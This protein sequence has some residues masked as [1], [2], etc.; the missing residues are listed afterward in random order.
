MKKIYAK[1]AKFIYSILTFFVFSISVSNCQTITTFAGNYFV[2][3]G[4]SGDGGL[5]VNAQLNAPYGIAVD[6]AGNVYFADYANN[7]IR[8]I[9]A[10][11]HAIST[12][13]GNGQS[14]YSGDGGAA[15]SAQ[16]RLPTSVAIDTA[17]NLYIGDASYT[18]RKVDALT[19]TISTVAGNGTPGF[20]GDGGL[21]T[22]ASIGGADGLLVDKAGNIYIADFS[23]NRIRKVD[24]ITHFISTIAGNGTQ[25]FSGDSALA[26]AAELSG[27]QGVAEDTKG[28][29][30]FADF[31][32]NRIR[33]IDGSTQI[34]STV[35]GNGVAGYA[36]DGTVATLAEVTP[37]SVATDTSD[38]IYIPENS[39]RIRK[40]NAGTGN[41]STIAGTGTAAFAGDG[42]PA[43]S[44]ELAHPVAIILDNTGNIFISDENNDRVR[45]ISATTQNIST[46]AGDYLSYGGDGGVATSAVFNLPEDV[47]FDR[48]GNLYISDAHDYRIRKISLATN[49][50][51]TVAGNGAAGYTKDS[52]PADSSALNFPEGVVTDSLGNVFF[53]DLDNYRIREIKTTDNKLYNFAGNGSS[54]GSF[55]NNTPAAQAYLSNPQGIAMDTA[56]NVF[57]ADWGLSMVLKIDAI[58][59][60]V[61]AVAGT[62]AWG[63][64]GDG[65]PATN[66]QLFFPW[67]VTLDRAGNIYIADAEN[68]RIR[69]VDASTN[70][71]T[72]FAGNGTN[73]YSGD[74]GPATNAEIGFTEGITTDSADNVYIS[75][76]STVRRIDA[77]TNIITTVAGVD[78]IG[79][80]GDNG[81]ATQAHLNG[82]NGVAFDRSGNMYIADY[83]NNVIR[84]VTQATLPVT[85]LSFTV[86]KK[87]ATALLNWQ[88][89]T[90]VNNA[91][92]DVERGVNS[93]NF[94]VIGKVAGNGNAA[95][96]QSYSFTDVA[97][98]EGIDYYRLKQVDKDG[99]VNYSRVLSLDFNTPPVLRLYPDPAKD[100][101]TVSGLSTNG[102][103]VIALIDAAG[104]TISVNVT[105]ANSCS[106]NVSQL[107]PG[108]YFLRII[109]N[110]Q[111]T[112][113]KFVKE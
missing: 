11:S 4:Y 13:A 107:N 96:A 83:S 90:E 77:K 109:T 85:Y 63:S 102:K 41:I 111:A 110:K 64:G 112:S 58:T 103:S 70:I 65:G 60:I 29:I 78:T 18:I 81:P 27:P 89:A 113:M 79:Y 73:G 76:Y 92:F 20:S 44:A 84:K 62:G 15:T 23:N 47:A 86:T 6:K 17:G 82:P 80:S 45:K 21:A 7:R 5:A 46:L 74:N 35:A 26:T 32:N 2:A 28:N 40:I 53:C 37:L 67:D 57:V 10:V 12:Y 19:Q 51:T 99:N 54:S 30:Y 31:N 72:T 87:G 9:D 75:A 3:P 59:K 101:A 8:K 105:S 24:A 69:K 25:G 39:N 55:Q 42:G 71:I 52:L 88:T 22:K 50:I 48:S 36:G 34:I 68:A 98:K 33:K 49:I 100:I 43:L 56:G 61:T 95:Q 91:Y 66:A 94:S 16:L 38:N 93:F 1:S 104:K 106:I 108:T 14:G 97:P